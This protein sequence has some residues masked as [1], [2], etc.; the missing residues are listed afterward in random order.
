MRILQVSSA[1]TWGGGET[2]VRELTDFL[3]AL[4]HDISIAG[5]PG[6]PLKPQIE[7]PFLN[8]F[9]FLTA[10]RLRRVLKRGAFD[11]VHAHVARDYPI[12]AAAAWGIASLKVVLTRH[13]LL[14]IR[15]HGLYRRVDAWIAPTSQI[16]GTITPLRPKKAEVIPNWIDIEKFAFRPHPVH[17]PITMGL[18]GQISPHKGHGDAIEAVRRLGATHRLLIAGEGDASYVHDLK[19]RSAGLPV[20]FLGFVPAAEFFQKADIL[21]MPSWEE[22]FGI[23]LLEA[24]AAGIPVIATNRGGPLEIISSPDEGVLL[25]PHDPAALANAIQSRNADTVASARARVEK[26]FDVRVVIPRIEGLYR[27]L[28]LRSSGHGG[29]L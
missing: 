29:A 15:R 27:E 13:L 21:L 2:H 16:L 6:S 3:R 20:E 5:R 23:V 11:I 4:G 7:L 8:S 18:L 14:P 25:P 22:P 17:S 9:D 28:L 26:R 24:M 1:E 12:I 19:K 10:I